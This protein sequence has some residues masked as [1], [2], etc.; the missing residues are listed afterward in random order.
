MEQV[1]RLRARVEA[2]RD[3]PDADP[4][5]S[6][7]RLT[8]YE[9][10]LQAGIERRHEEV[11]SSAVDYTDTDYMALTS[12]R[13]FNAAAPGAS[14][15]EDVDKEKADISSAA[16]KPVRTQGQGAPKLS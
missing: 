14:I 13:A 2:E 3:A 10:E 4:E 8:D 6:Q 7:H 15:A 5:Q 11:V 12:A 1:A 9:N 16:S